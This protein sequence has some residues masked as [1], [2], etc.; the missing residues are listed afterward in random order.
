MK[1]I[2]LREYFERYIKLNF[3]EWELLNSRMKKKTFSKGEII[4]YAGDVSTELGFITSGIARHFIYDADGNDYTWHI[5]FN[6][7]DAKVQNLFIVDF[8]SFVSQKPGRLNT[9]AL[10]DCEVL[11]CK[12]ADLQKL[13]FLAKK[14]ERAGRLIVEEAYQHVHNR[15]IN[16]TIQTAKERYK[17]FLKDYAY[18]CDKVPQY[19]IASFLNITPQ[20]L[21]TLKK[22]LKKK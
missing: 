17:T 6:T 15:A 14:Y 18:V 5:C 1:S 20:H 21:S 9:E 13:F 16:L 19:H 3:I 22:E 8:D 10:T 4:H 11:Y 12:H 7:E 2:T